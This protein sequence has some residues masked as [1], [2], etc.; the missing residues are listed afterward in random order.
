[1]IGNAAAAN[2]AA[3]WSGRDGDPPR[4]LAA[5]GPAGREPVAVTRVGSEYL[6]FELAMVREF[7]TTRQVTPVPC[8]PPHIAGQMNLRGDIV[9]LVDLRP[10]M[11]LPTPVGEPL[12][13]VVLLELEELRKIH[14]K[15]AT[16]S[17]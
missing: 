5:G 17:A 2:E 16:V 11:K 1:M 6:G 3:A 12:S 14:I 7:T 4:P 13:R 8:C 10:V 15:R 9:T